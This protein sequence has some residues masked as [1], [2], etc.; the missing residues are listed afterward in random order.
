[1]NKHEVIHFE[2]KI[3]VP[4]SDSTETYYLINK[5]MAGTNTCC[6]QQPGKY[7]FSQTIGFYR[8]DMLES[9]TIDKSKV[10]DILVQNGYNEE[11][12]NDTD[13]PVSKIVLS[14]N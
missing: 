13:L 14:N 3:Y 6:R 8:C 9:F 1:M 7:E 4:N 10:I 5:I 11:R 2:D 12:V